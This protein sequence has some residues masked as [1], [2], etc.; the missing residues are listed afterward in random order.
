MAWQCGGGV[1][2]LS[3]L[4]FPPLLAFEPAAVHAEVIAHYVQLP[5]RI[6]FKK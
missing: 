5:H 2:D 1:S 3:E 4:C 6:G